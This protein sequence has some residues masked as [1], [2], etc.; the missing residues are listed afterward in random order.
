MSWWPLGC[1]DKGASTHIRKGKFLPPSPKGLSRFPS[2]PPREC[3]GPSAYPEVLEARWQSSQPG[4]RLCGH[5]LVCGL[6]EQ[7][8]RVALLG[9][10]SDDLSGSPAQLSPQLWPLPNV[11]EDRAVPVPHVSPSLRSIL[12][13]RSPASAH[14][15][16]SA[17]PLRRSAGHGRLMHCFPCGAGRTTE[18]RCLSPASDLA[19]PPAPACR[20]DRSDRLQADF[21]A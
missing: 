15:G 1:L 13:P 7:K 9:S 20:G 17:Q 19:L 5:R 2:S 8:G 10:L 18:A 4:S 14:G 3:P 6:Q 11:G 16:R 21:K 12:P